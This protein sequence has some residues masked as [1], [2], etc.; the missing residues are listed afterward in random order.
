MVRLPAIEELEVA[1]AASVG[2]G[3]HDMRRIERCLVLDFQV[4]VSPMQVLEK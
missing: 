4:A 2:Y 3:R 1:L